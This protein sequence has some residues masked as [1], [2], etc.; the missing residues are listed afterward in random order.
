MSIRHH[1]TRVTNCEGFVWSN[2]RNCERFG[3]IIRLMLSMD[4]YVVTSVLVGD[5]LVLISILAHSLQT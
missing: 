1:W 2:M 4:N 3:E 5:K